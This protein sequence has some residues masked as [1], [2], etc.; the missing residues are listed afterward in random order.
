MDTFY[1]M[2]AATA[3]RPDIIDTSKATADE[4]RA[5]WGPMLANSGGYEISGIS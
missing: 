5:I 2:V 3:G 1:S 4:P